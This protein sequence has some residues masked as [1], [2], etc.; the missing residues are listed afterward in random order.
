MEEKGARSVAVFTVYGSEDVL[1]FYARY[2][3]H[4]KMLMLE[5]KK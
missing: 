3:F 5:L 4:P 1:P 2:G